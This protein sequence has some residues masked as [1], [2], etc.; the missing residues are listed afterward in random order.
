VSVLATYRMLGRR[1][2]DGLQGRV[3]PRMRW[4]AR[5]G[6]DFDKRH[7]RLEFLRGQLAPDG[8]G[9][10][11]VQPNPA[12][13]SHRLRAAAASNALIVLPEGPRAF[14]AGEVVDVLPL[15]AD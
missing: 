10:L 13:G 11:R 15:G 12:D 6:A 9:G 5:L 4:Q 1:L 2:L 14:R 3:A 7:D 8:E